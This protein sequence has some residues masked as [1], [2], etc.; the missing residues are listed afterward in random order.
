MNVK[1]DFPH[2]IREI[3]H[4]EIPLADGTRLAARIWLPED[5][6]SHPVPAILEYLPYRKRDGTAVRDEL[7]HP[8]FAGHG[9]AAVRVDM[10]GNGE[11][12]G[13]MADEYLPQEQAD[14][15]EVIDW[16]TRQPWCNGKLGMM[17]ISWGGFNSLQLAALKPEPLK[18]I[19]TLCSTDDRYTDDIHYKGG[20]LL[21]ENL[22]WSATMLSFSAAPPDPALVGDV[23]RERWKERLD[24]MPLLA[25]TWMSHQ[26]R[27]AYW[28][29]GSVNQNYADIEAAV[30]AVGGWGDGYK[31]SVPRLLENL[32]GPKKGLI[33][34]WIHKYPHFAVPDPAI[35]FL[36][37]ALRWWD[38]WLKDIDTGVMDEPAGTFYLQDALPPKPMYAER[39]G[40]WVRTEGWP[41]SC[42]EH[43]PFALTDTGLVPGD[44]SLAQ[45]KTVDSPLTAGSHQGEYCAIWFGPDLPG[46]QRQDDALALCFDSEPLEAPLDILGK[47]RLRLRLASDQPCGQLTV[48]LSD[49]RPDGQVA[50][51]TYGVLNLSLRDH[52]L[53]EP[54]VPGEPM[55]VDLELD[56]IGYRLPAG[57]R[58]RV[59][60]ASANFPL[61]W[62][63]ARRAALT[64]EPGL[65]RLELPV[66]QGETVE[67]PFEAPES[68]RPANVDTQRRPAPRRTI[69]E[70]VASGEVTVIV[71]DDLGA[72]TLADHGYRVAQSCEERYTAHPEDPTRARAEIVWHYR[73]GR[74]EGPGRFDVSVESRYRLTCDEMTFFIE[75]EQ[76]AHDDGEEVHRRDWRTTV[77]R[78][79]I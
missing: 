27:D 19:I 53:L 5:A 77:P 40:A 28:K 37:E 72:M 38:H 16:L 63:T 33:G 59:A 51:I 4:L 32:P 36:Q 13:V 58:L 3:E 76:I 18:A 57:H 47:P 46:D 42:V 17:G 55:D 20:N 15:L 48:R 14:G 21:H 39:P 34:P 31:N 9:Y 8:Y 26:T 68:A 49:V 29:H 50:R 74:D 79:A 24:N 11:S 12:E 45:P 23:W 10:R 62:P 35:G 52:D 70:D 65:Q 54:P 61:L 6:E 7:T 56:M 44:A 43:R 2:R 22:G 60:V 64:L 75:A 66:F 30:Y 78:R 67:S 71:E 73:A 25:E 69:Q 1:T 41:A